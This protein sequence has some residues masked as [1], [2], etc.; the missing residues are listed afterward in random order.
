MH[1]TKFFNCT[2]IL[3]KKMYSYISI[4][5]KIKTIFFS[6][7]LGY[8]SYSMQSVWEKPQQ[9]PSPIL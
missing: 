3:Q 5:L 2:M 4:F 9:R 7:K 8:I 6:L 1:E